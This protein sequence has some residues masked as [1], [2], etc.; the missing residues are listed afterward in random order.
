MTAGAAH[1]YSQIALAFALELRQ[2]ISQQIREASQRLLDFGRRAQ[3]FDYRLVSA[4]QRPQLR[5]KMRV[6]QE[7]DVEHHADS[8]GQPVPVTKRYYADAHLV[9]GPFFAEPVLDRV[10]ERMHGV[11]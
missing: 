6:R 9:P 5:N 3:V 11:F 2:Q 10:S 8:S 7:P 4:S 1:P